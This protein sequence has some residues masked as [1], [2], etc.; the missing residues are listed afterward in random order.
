MRLG[1]C[2]VDL[3]KDVHLS[4]RLRE[5]KGVGGSLGHEQEFNG[6]LPVA[7]LLAVPRNH[8]RAG[9]AKRHRHSAIRFKLKEPF[10]RDIA[11]KSVA[12]RGHLIPTD[13]LYTRW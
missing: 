12:V 7:G 5:A 13:L 6:A 3:G 9:A 4:V 1:A 2:V 8:L 11:G 10:A